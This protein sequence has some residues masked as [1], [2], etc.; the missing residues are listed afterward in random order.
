MTYFQ[1]PSV[2][3]SFSDDNYHQE[4]GDISHEYFPDS[5]YEMTHQKARLISAEEDSNSV[6]DY[7]FGIKGL[8]V[9]FWVESKYRNIKQLNEYIS[10]FKAGQLDRL[11][12]F[13]NSFLFLRV[14]IQRE[15][16]SF[17][18]PIDDIKTDE[19]HFSFLRP[20]LLTI[21]KPVQP[22]LIMKYL[23]SSDLDFPSYVSAEIWS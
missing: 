7:R 12:A 20:Y 2:Y 13:E 19:L 6:P 15:D 17:F 10:V 8:R 14:R 11:K 21:A 18:I 16:Y 9:A 5:H 3:G 22:N 1:L 23:N 4:T